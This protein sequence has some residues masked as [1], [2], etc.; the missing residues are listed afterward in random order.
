MEERY[1][2]AIDPDKWIRPAGWLQMPTIT[3]AENKLAFLFAVYENE[4]NCFTLNYGSAT[5]NYTVDWGDGTAPLTVI[6]ST[7][8][9][10]KRYDYSLISSIVLQDS[11]GIN[12]KQVIVTVTLNSGTIVGWVISPSSAAARTGKSQILESVLSHSHSVSFSARQQPL[13]ESLKIIKLIPTATVSNQYQNFAAL[14]NF[15]GFENIDTTNTTTSTSTFNAIGPIWQVLNFT[16]NSGASGM[17]SILSGSRIKKFGNVTLLGTGGLTTAISG[18]ASLEEIGDINLGNHTTLISMFINNFSLKK[19]GTI[20]IG[21]TAVNITSMFQ[22]CYSL[23]EIV[24]TDCS[25][26]T[27]LASTTFATCVSLRRLVLPGLRFSVVTPVGSLQRTALVE[28]FNSLA[29][30]TSLPTQNITITGNPGLDDLTAAE[31]N[32]IL[33]PKNWTYTP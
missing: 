20:T 29:D 12:Y 33:V 11:F 22:N 10:T 5:C 19:I 4:E 28:L 6:N 25:N 17:T 32:A 23:E 9:Q 1:I 18:C 24:F 31:I 21:G 8:I 13:M 27:T 15:E 3:A 7:T 16:W 14:R 2:K 30:L 26:V